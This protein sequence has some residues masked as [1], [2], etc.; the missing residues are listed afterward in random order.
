MRGV[1]SQAFAGSEIDF[2]NEGSNIIFRRERDI[3]RF[4]LTNTMVSGSFP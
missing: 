1:P 4:V 2:G 3:K